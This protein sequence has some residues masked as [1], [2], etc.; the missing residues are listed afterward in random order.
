MASEWGVGRASVMINIRYYDETE[1]YACGS[2]AV[3][4]CGRCW[5]LAVWLC[6]Y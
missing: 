3:V 5:G 2:S 6:I 1:D 4:A